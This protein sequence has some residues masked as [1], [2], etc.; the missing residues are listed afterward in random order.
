MYA[1]ALQ[2]TA[3][4]SFTA[5]DTFQPSD[6]YIQDKKPQIPHVTSSS[7]LMV[8]FYVID[9]I[10]KLLQSYD[11]RKLIE[12]FEGLMASDIHGTKLLG[13]E[14][15]DLNKVD[16]PASLLRYAST[17]SDHSITK[18][19]V[20]SCNEAMKLLDEFDS[21]LDL[22]QPISSYPIPPFSSDM[23]PPTTSTYTVLAIRYDQELYKC[24]LQCV[25]DVRSLIIEKCD[26]TLHCLQLLAINSHLTIFYWTL[27]K[28][29]VSLISSK[30][31]EISECLYFH[32]IL[33]ILVYPTPLLSTSDDGRVGLLAFEMEIDKTD[34]DKNEV[35]KCCSCS[36]YDCNCIVCLQICPQ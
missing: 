12:K 7:V 21:K 15:N 27:P 18:V 19:L 2:S 14:I 20:S 25:Y 6:N 4:G 31:P 33:E 3:N 8:F 36:L 1:L 24:T 28:S 22:S 35:R 10:S 29:V 11:P 23:I 26:I 5:A 13:D 9:E 17:W 16:N 34:L 30:V 32:G